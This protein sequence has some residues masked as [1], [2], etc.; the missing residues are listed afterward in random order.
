MGRLLYQL[1]VCVLVCGVFVFGLSGWWLWSG[2]GGD[3]WCGWEGR[4]LRGGVGCG[5]C[6]GVQLHTLSLLAAAFQPIGHLRR[7]RR[8]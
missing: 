2:E 5:G 4:E 1:C 7:W 6:G 3:A 8:R